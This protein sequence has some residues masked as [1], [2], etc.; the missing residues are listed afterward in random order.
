MRNRLLPTLL[1]FVAPLVVLLVPAQLARA[2]SDAS[3][4]RASADKPIAALS[5]PISNE[6]TTTYWAYSV[7]R[8]AIRSGPSS[9]A[10]EITSTTLWTED[11][12]PQN[13]L[14]LAQDVY[15]N[16]TWF[17][18]RIPGRPNGRVGW[19]REQALGTLHVTHKLVVVNER[20]LRLTFYVWGRKIWSAPVGIGAPDAPTPTGH[21]WIRENMG[22]LPASN[23]YYPYAFGTSDYSTLSDWP[24]GGVVGIHGPYGAPPS[25]IPGRISHGCV[26][27]RIADMRW[28]GQHLQVGIPVRIEG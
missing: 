1:R 17:E 26:R 14:V 23:P 27:L 19:V 16:E 2:E 10:R 6:S 28:L 18:I 5:G 22:A 13:Y 4:A 24:K 25:A 3:V 20:S 9:K 7:E 15:P 12:F 21:F 11:S 8:A